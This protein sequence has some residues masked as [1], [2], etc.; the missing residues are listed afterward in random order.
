VIDDDRG[1]L[2]EPGG[3]DG[4]LDAMETLLNDPRRRERM[5]ASNRRAV[6]TEYSWDS[7]L[8]EL[9]DAYESCLRT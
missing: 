6:E 7:A 4:L 5:A 2:V 1:L 3:V 8:A 9:R